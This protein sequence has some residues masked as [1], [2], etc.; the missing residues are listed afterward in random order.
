MKKIIIFSFII[1]CSLPICAQ[2]IQRSDK[3]MYGIAVTKSNGGVKWIVKPKYTQIEKNLYYSGSFSVLDENGRWGVVTSGGK[4]VVPC[5]HATKD[6]AL[7]AYSHYLNPGSKTYASNGATGSVGNDSYFTLTRD[8]TTYIKDYVERNINQWQKKGEFE[9]TADYQKRVTES[10]RRQKVDQLTKEV[11]D[12]CLQKVQDK[13]LRMTL[14]EYDADHETFLVTTDLGKFVLPVSIS[15]APTFKKNWSKIISQNTYDIVN[16]KIVLRSATFKL[17]NKTVASYSDQNHALYAQANINYNFDPIEIQLQDEST[18][19]QP[20]IAQNNISVG[21]SDIDI[22]IPS[23]SSNNNKTFALIFAN[24]NYREEVP[25]AYAKNDGASV[26]KYFT[27][28][29]GIPQKNV[30]FVTD[31]T[32][33]DMIREIDWLKNIASVYDDDINILVYYA[34][35]GVP[36]ESNGNTC[37]VPIDGVGSN[38]K[39]LYQLSEFYKEI[40]AINT[41][42][43]VIFMDA[44]FSGAIRGNGM[45]ASARG[46]A[47]RAKD[48][49]PKESMIVLTAAQGDETAWPYEEKG[50]GLFTYFLLKKLQD[51]KGNATIGELA[52]YV[53]DQVGK[54]SIV[55]NSKRQTPT[56]NVSPKMTGVWSNLKL[57]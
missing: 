43:T 21:K 7:E 26:E 1:I 22:N 41:A 38:P 13:E 29:L 49:T 14:G 18:I 44:C 34:G 56:V 10:I 51:S 2:R 50:H 36:D 8:Y 5:V 46:I 32:K 47:L 16:G 48:E 40:G 33:N 24:E 45:L 27:Q 39:T 42:S 3:G 9:K 31:A 30:H 19:N 12:E 57:R 15:Q 6:A 25:V 11:C 52:D 53:K 55:V 28:T 17:N 35:H 23:N 20:R 4:E 54:H 37:L